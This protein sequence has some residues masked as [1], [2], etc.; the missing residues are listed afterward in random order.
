MRNRTAENSSRHGFL[1][2]VSRRCR[3]ARSLARARAR[4]RGHH[5]TVATLAGKDLA[6]DEDDNGVRVRRLRSMSQRMPWLFSSPETAV[7]AAGSRSGHHVATAQADRR[8]TLLTS[9]TATIGWRV[10][11]CRCAG[12]AR[13]GT[14]P[15]SSPR[16]TTTR[17]RAPRRT[18]CARNASTASWRRPPAADPASAS[19]WP[20]QPVTTEWRPGVFT[21]TANIAGAL[22]ERRGATTIVAVSE[23]V[24]RGNGLAPDDAKS[25]SCPTSSRT[26][27]QAASQRHP[28]TD[29][30]AP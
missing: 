3:A 18:S 12:G 26:T 2:A 21:A 11:S 28:P 1:L 7:G 6:D 14:A 16:C 20:V 19:A 4:W 27:D 23:A 25:W 30:V 17:S 5:V 8:P 15:G 29:R 24:A 22:A 9:C 10:R 13:G